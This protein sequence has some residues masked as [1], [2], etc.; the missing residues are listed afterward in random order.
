M[1]NIQQ[2]ENTTAYPFT[3][4][5]FEEL[6]WLR[7][8]QSE[9]GVGQY[10]IAFQ[11]SGTVDIG[12]MLAAI[13]TACRHCP[14]LQVLYQFDDDQGLVKTANPQLAHLS[15]VKSVTHQQTALDDILALQMTP[16]DLHSEAALQFTLYLLA[17]AHTN[18]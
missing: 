13:E 5:E 8:Q 14:P 6:T 18:P 15:R 16:L 9:A 2:L 4:S 10:A 17:D 12:R 11:L 1:E 3:L 7:H